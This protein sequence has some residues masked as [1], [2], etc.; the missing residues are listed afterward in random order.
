MVFYV[1]RHV[2][3]TVRTLHDKSSKA[4]NISSG[5]VRVDEVCSCMNKMYV[6]M[7]DLRLFDLGIVVASVLFFTKLLIFSFLA[8]S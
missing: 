8:K 2:L 4:C 6:N 1:Y 7:L 3:G 5:L